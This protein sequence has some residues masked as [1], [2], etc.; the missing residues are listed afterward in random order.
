MSVNKKFVIMTNPNGFQMRDDAIAEYATALE[1]KEH[2]APGDVI[3]P[4]AGDAEVVDFLTGKRP[5]PI[6]NRSGRR[7]G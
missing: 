7:D 2:M 6:F 3:V 4:I 1:A 5:L